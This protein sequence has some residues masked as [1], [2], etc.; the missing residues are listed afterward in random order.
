MDCVLLTGATGHLG[1]YLVRDLI[2][3]GITP[4]ILIRNS[5][6][7]AEERF[8]HLLTDLQINGCSPR[9][10]VLISGDTGKPNFG[11]APSA[12]DWI[13]SC[14]S[15]L[16][17]CAASVQFE[18]GVTGETMRQNLEAAEHAVD[19][20]H[21]CNFQKMVYVSTAYVCGQRTGTILE[22]DL[23]CNQTFRNEYEHSKMLAEHRVRSAIAPSQLVVLRPAIIVGDSV[24]GAS[25]QFHSIYRFAQFTSL[26]ANAAPKDADGRWEHNVRL[27]VPGYKSLN[28]VAVD[29]VSAASVAIMQRFDFRNE[30]NTFHLTPA[31]PTLLSE[32]EAALQQCFNYTGVRFVDQIEDLSDSSDSEKFFYSY[33]SKYLEYWRDDPVFDR[34]NTNL[35]ISDVPEQR[36]DTETLARMFQFAVDT[37]FGR[38]I[39]RN[40]IA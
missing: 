26:L 12:I 25:R 9:L 5:R 31:V 20:F 1:R 32:I 6:V 27:T 38:N 2:D 16:I 13:R 34:T 24:N 33:V 7:T 14:C 30:V 15:Q 4:V 11:L 17:H 8:R 39:S 28:L 40:R 22:S 37:K 23:D 3:R 21:T 10:P 18:G 29:W 19:M 36:I 35:Y